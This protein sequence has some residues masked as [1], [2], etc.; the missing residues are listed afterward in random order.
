MAADARAAMLE[1][2]AEDP[3]KVGLQPKLASVLADVRRIPKTGFNDKQNYKFAR[4][5]DIADMIRDSL[6]AHWIAFKASIRTREDGSLS[7][8]HNVIQSR[9]GTAGVEIVVD[10][11]ITLTCAHT[12]ETETAVWQGVATDYTD[13]A[14]MKA[15][16]AAKKSYLVFTFLV[17]TGDE[18]ADAGGI[19]RAGQQQRQ[20]AQ[21]R[22][23][24]QGQAQPTA[25]QIKAGRNADGSPDTRPAS[26]PQRRR[27]FGISK[28]SPFLTTQ[29]EKGRKVNDVA[30]HNL[31]AWVTR[32]P[33]VDPAGPVTSLS[34]LTKWQM[35]RVYKVIEDSNADAELAGKVAASVDEW[36]EGNQA[37]AAPTGE[38][39]QA[40]PAAEEPADGEVERNPGTS[41]HDA[42][43]P[44]GDDAKEADGDEGN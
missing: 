32:K 22:P 24:A 16:T 20:Q 27:L 44:F 37:A 33:E 29:T 35:A 26:E 25:E 6:A 2:L 19:E 5:G 8:I 28:D 43:I 42:T 39:S 7:V 11:D 21:Q 23:Q 38:E 40:E 9:G 17:S 34:D 31:V 41:E 1:H 10:V 36:I 4:E 30:L 15:L 14:L 3:P 12:G 13:K 18:E